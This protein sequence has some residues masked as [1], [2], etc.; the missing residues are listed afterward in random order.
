LTISHVFATCAEVIVIDEI[1]TEAECLAAR[2]IA[3]RGV[4]LVATAHGEAGG[5]KQHRSIAVVLL[6]QTPLAACL[7]GSM[8]E[9]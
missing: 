3:Q 5:Q 9:G 7:I 8:F 2:T 4:Q 6:R 1:G